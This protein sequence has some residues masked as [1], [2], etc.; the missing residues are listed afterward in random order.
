MF[1]KGWS[2]ILFRETIGEE[3]HYSFI[4]FPTGGPYSDIKN[5]DV[6]IILDRVIFA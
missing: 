6:V 5:R 1:L 2:H 4:I 3:T